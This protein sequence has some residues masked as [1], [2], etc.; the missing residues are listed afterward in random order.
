M[1]PST[2][3]RQLTDERFAGL[4]THPQFRGAV[5]RATSESIAHFQSLDPTYRWITKDIGRATISA[6][7]LTLYL[8]GDLTLQSLT[9]ACVANNISSAGR[10]QQVV[11]R[12]QA[13]G[14]VTVPDGPEIWTRRP[15]RLGAELIN[16]LRERALIDLRAMLTLA[17]E[18]AGAA[19]L[20]ATDEGFASYLI[21]LMTIA[22]LRNDVFDLQDASPIAVLLDREAGMLMLFDLIGAQRP[23]RSLLLEQAPISRFALARRYGVSRAHINKILADSGHMT[24]VGVD[25]V[26]FSETLSLAME[27]HFAVV[28]ALNQCA[29]EA[30]LSGWRFDP[31]RGGQAPR[32]IAS[33]KPAAAPEL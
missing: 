12:C 14:A 21:C 29:A 26:V 20:A 7:A 23:D 17:P 2:L 8:M 19:D 10:V 6:T 5:E 22:R 1:T 11:R 32:R 16:L 18:L 3:A 13:V 33:I 15:M 30:L 25:R 31:G 27:R 24:C 28:F 9:A 4:R